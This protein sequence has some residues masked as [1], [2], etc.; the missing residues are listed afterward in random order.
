MGVS[1]FGRVPG[2]INYQGNTS[3]W[4]NPFF[5]LPASDINTAP[6][7]V[8]LIQT[9]VSIAENATTVTRL[10]LTDIIVSDDAFGTNYTT[11]TGSDASAFETVDGALY[12]KAGVVLNFEA[13]SSY[14]VTVRVSDSYLSGSSPVAATFTLAV[15][16]VSEPSRTEAVQMPA[17]KAY[18]AGDVL[19]FTLVVSQPVV[20]TGKPTIPIV[21]GVGRKSAVYAS[22]SG[23]NNLVFQYVVGRRDNAANIFV[24]NAIVLPTRRTMIRDASGMRLPLAIAGGVVPG[25]SIDTMAPTVIG[26]KVTASRGNGLP[27]PLINVSIRYSIAVRFSESVIVSGLPGIPVR[28]DKGM[29]GNAVYVSGSGSQVLVFQSTHIAPASFPLNKLPSLGASIALNGGSIT[30]AAGNWARLTINRRLVRL[31]YNGRSVISR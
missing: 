3:G 27:T 19:R 26:V 31:E 17:G 30:D 21:A 15:T 8:S 12:L 22:G 13:Q 24:G 2:T 10:K 14:S 11:F 9:S 1:V 7:A 4:S 18:K 28:L 20:V 23:T 5:E 16:D 6:T 29:F 25:A